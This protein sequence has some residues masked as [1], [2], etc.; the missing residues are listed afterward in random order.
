VVLKVEDL[1]RFDGLVIRLEDEIHFS[2]GM[3]RS[4]M[5]WRMKV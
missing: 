2:L 4:N 5:G 3:E 1:K